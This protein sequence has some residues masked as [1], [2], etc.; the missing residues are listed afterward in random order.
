M[1]IGETPED[2]ARREVQEE[3]G[4]EV[5]I[6]GLM[7]VYAVPRI[8]QV[9][10]VYLADMLSPEFSAGSESLDVQF[11]DPVV[12]RLPWDDLAFPV[13][14]WTLR[15]YLSLQGRPVGQPFTTRPDDLKQRMSRVDFHP[16]FPPPSTGEASA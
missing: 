5:V 10:M 8:G 13:N 12:Q 16:D 3:A 1:E 14:H 15:D 7:G 11:F 4:A 6:R 9:H 2:G